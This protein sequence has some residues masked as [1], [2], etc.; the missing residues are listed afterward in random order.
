MNK[1]E[2]YLGYMLYR[3]QLSEK[4]AITESRDSTLGNHC[5][6]FFPF[7]FCLCFAL[8]FLYLIFHMILRPKFVNSMTFDEFFQNS[9]LKRVK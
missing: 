7:Y 5:S 8:S 3:A 4:V 1:K 2:R 9:T 6:N